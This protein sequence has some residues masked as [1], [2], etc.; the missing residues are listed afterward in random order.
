MNIRQLNS[1]LCILG[2]MGTCLSAQ[3]KLDGGIQTGLTLPVGDLK[4]KED[5]GTNNFFGAHVGGHLDF[6]IT[7]H[8]QVRG[9]ITY[10]IMPG[11]RFSGPLQV[12]NDFKDLQFGADW[13]YNFTS[14]SSGGYFLAGANFNN[15]QVDFDGVPG[16][17][18][19]SQSGRLG[20]RVGGGYTFSRAFSLEGSF[21]QANVD[22]FGPDGFGFDTASWIQVSAVF[23]FGR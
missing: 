1:S 4:D 20:V 5:F 13:V 16:S 6:N 11:T 22:K 18:S 9:E 15:F 3:V 17:G 21:N 12:K 23:R 14:P 19:S 2:F 7:P 10:H 8:H